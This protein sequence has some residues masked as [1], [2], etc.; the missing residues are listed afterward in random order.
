MKFTRWASFQRVAMVHDFFFAPTYMTLFEPVYLYSILV[1]SIS[2]CRTN[3]DGQPVIARA[4]YDFN[5]E[6]S[7]ELSF[8]AGDELVC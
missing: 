1:G 2:L 5:T 8:L 3:S 4:L 6:R 7:G